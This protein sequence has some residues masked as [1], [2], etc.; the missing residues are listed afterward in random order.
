MHKKYLPAV[1]LLLSVAACRDGANQAAIPHGF[2]EK[3]VPKTEFSE[4]RYPGPAVP[5]RGDNQYVLP[6]DHGFVFL[7]GEKPMGGGVRAA[8]TVTGV[9]EGGVVLSTDAGILSMRYN[10]PGGQQLA[11]KSGAAMSVSFTRGRGERVTDFMI[12]DST[13]GKLLHA[14]G[15]VN[16]M[17]PVHIKIADGLEIYQQPDAAA[18]VKP[19]ALRWLNKSISVGRKG[20]TVAAIDGQMYSVLVLDSRE[21]HPAPGN[22]LTSEGEGFYL[23]YAVVKQ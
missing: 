1:C 5:A 18:D 21:L 7:A 6:K 4:L 19:V 8:G 23:E 3:M 10:L 20:G 13:D 11:V 16:S 14:S 22:E 9:S 2:D 17:Q 12:V 15:R